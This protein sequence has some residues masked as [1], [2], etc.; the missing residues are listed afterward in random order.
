MDLISH[1]LVGLL[2]GFLYLAPPG[3]VNL[4]VVRAALDHHRTTAW[5][6]A[7][8]AASAEMLYCMLSVFG[9]ALTEANQRVFF[10]LKVISVPVLLGMGIY[11]LF[12]KP[13]ARTVSQLAREGAAAERAG[14]VLLQRSLPRGSFFLGFGL[15]VLN[16]TLFGLYFGTAAWLRGHGWLSDEFWP[17]A[18]YVLAVGLGG[19]LLLALMAWQADRHQKLMG[20]RNLRRL[21]IFIGVFFISFALYTLYTLLKG[22]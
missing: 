4:S 8:G 10:W 22:A 16:P 6:I 21:Y 13:K 15:N 1:A 3:P 14:E 18:T 9:V 12:K 7:A 19:W 5:K 17:L 11:S 2:L 20:P